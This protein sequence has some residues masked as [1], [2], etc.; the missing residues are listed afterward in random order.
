MVIVSINGMSTFLELCEKTGS[1]ICICSCNGNLTAVQK[2]VTKVQQEETHV[3][4]YHFLMKHD[5]F[6]CL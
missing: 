5:S 4:S 1:N 6:F 3:I 2:A